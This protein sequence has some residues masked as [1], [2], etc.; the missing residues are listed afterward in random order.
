MGT[1]KGCVISEHSYFRIDVDLMLG[2]KVQLSSVET[3]ERLEERR[4]RARPSRLIEDDARHF[5]CSP[6]SEQATNEVRARRRMKIYAYGVIDS[7]EKIM[8]P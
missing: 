3:M 4:F 1:E 5:V 2:L 8:N 7:S 6:S